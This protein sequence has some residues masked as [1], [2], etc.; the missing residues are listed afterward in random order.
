MLQ[1]FTY[2]K[3]DN[4]VWSIGTP[5]GEIAVYIYLID[6]GDG[7]VLFD[8]GLKKTAKAVF[9][10]LREV[11]RKAE[12]IVGIVISHSHHDHIGAIAELA[13]T[14]R[15]KVFAHTLAKDW[16]VDHQRQYHEFFGRFTQQIRLPDTFHTFF[17]ENLGRPWIADN[18]LNRF[19]Y[20]LPFRRK[21][22]IIYTPG[23]SQDGIS[24]WWP[25]KRILICGD[26]FMGAGVGGGLPQY[27][28]FHSYRATLSN[29]LDLAPALLLSGHFLKI[30]QNKVED[31]IHQSLRLTE[32]IDIFIQETLQQA[33]SGYELKVLVEMVC[34]RFGRP[35]APQAFITLLA[36]L[37]AYES[38]QLVYEENGR[39]SYGNEERTHLPVL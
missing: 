11:N 6:V 20:N 19:P 31:A 26:A 9:H 21:L 8:A 37:H 29:M 16:M 33:K 25:E 32:Q 3:V 4:S 5:L 35:L 22:E 7:L 18:W 30:G 12:E 1:D 2:E 28:D 17:F 13:E 15:A 36:H 14:S 23:H 24:L 34:R 27:S 10:L 38:K 39:W